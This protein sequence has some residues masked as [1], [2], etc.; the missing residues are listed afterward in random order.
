MPPYIY[1][2]D[3]I[4]MRYEYL[5]L[6][7]WLSCCD[8]LTGVAG[9]INC[10]DGLAGIGGS[11]WTLATYTRDAIYLASYSDISRE[12]IRGGCWHGVYSDGVNAI[13]IISNGM[14]IA[15]SAELATLISILVM[16]FLLIQLD[17]RI[18]EVLFAK[19]YLLIKYQ[20]ELIL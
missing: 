1:T 7:E 4:A 13:N 8:I 14:L 2:R 3:A 20:V 10:L 17:I 19:V 6:M 9:G 15:V 5:Y 18:L 16:Q 11:G 12:C